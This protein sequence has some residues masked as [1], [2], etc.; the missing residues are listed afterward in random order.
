LRPWQSWA[1]LYSPAM[2]HKASVI[3]IDEDEPAEKAGALQ[4]M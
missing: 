3:T 2:A 4:V 1:N